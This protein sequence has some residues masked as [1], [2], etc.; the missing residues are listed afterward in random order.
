MKL[1]WSC[2]ELA[3]GLQCYCREEFFE[4]HEHWELVWLKSQEPEKTFL[5]ALIQVAAAFH[6]LQ[7]KNVR[8]ATSLLKEALRRLDSYPSFFGG[9]AVGPLR[10]DVL[11]W[12]RVL[13]TESAAETRR[14][15]HI[16]PDGSQTEMGAS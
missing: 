15:P 13:E 5:Q 11:A 6:H 3:D 9:I 14:F 7:R 1:N 4:A 10:E 8:G 16:Q 2:G 12:V